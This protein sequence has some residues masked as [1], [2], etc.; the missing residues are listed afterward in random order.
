MDKKQ[1]ELN[2]ILEITQAINLNVKEEDLYRIFMFT[3]LANLSLNQFG[4]VVVSTNVV[5]ELK[6]N[7]KLDLSTADLSQ[8]L[9]SS[10]ESNQKSISYNSKGIGIILPVRHKDKLLGCLLI[11]E[12]IELTET[13][14]GFIKTLANIIMVAVENKR[15]FKSSLK[16]ERL[17]NELNIA[18][19]VQRNL[20]PKSF[21]D[22]DYFKAFAS[23]VPHASVG[24]D[25][26][27]V[28]KLSDG[29][30]LFCIA[31]VSGKGVPAAL[32]MSN[33]QAVL[34]TM[35]RQTT[36]VVAIVNELNYQVFKNARGSHFITFFVG[37][38]DVENNHLQYVNAG[39]NPPIL[40]DDK[41]KTRLLQDGTMV[42]GAFEE[43]PFLN[44]GNESLSTGDLLF[45]YTDGVTEVFNEGQEEFGEARLERF[46]ATKANE[47]NLENV[48]GSLV[49]YLDSY[50]GKISYSDDLT[51]VALKWVN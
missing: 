2:A 36:D 11:G 41:G 51:T 22:N 46:L 32:I 27:D 50:R 4:L 43:L 20:L 18:K 48:I 25:Y 39:H 35:V 6:V 9:Q 17:N 44:L 24:G 7:Q 29:K 5:P 19:D 49:A 42:L 10:E 47:D 15:L 38:I 37:V 1:L 12:N 13:E 28:V 40:V 3:C 26:Y 16:Q 45:L 21:P 31:D 23:Y 14:T 30:Y 34:H 33:F 8:M